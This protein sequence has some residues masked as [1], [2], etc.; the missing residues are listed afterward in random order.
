[1]SKKNSFFSVICLIFILGILNTNTV[2]ASST[3]GTINSTDKYAWGENIGWLNF[4]LADGN[5]HVTDSGLTGYA[6][7]ENYGWINLNANGTSGGRVTNNGEGVLGGN[8]WGEKLGWISFS[9]VTINS[10]GDF[11]GYA[12]I[13][14]DGSKISLNC[15][16]T[17]SCGLSNFKV[18]TDWR[19]ASTRPHGGGG[20]GGGG[21]VPSCTDKI[22]N[23]NETG[24][25][26]GGTCPNICQVIPPTSTEIPGCGN[27]TI[28]FSV[29]TGQS[30][31]GNTSTTPDIIPTAT[32][33]ILGSGPCSAELLITNNM[34]ID[35][36]NGKYSAYNKGIVTQVK[37][38]QTQIN[39][40]LAASYKQAAGPMDGFFGLLTK[41]GVERLQVALNNILKPT[42]L[43]V[44]DGIVGDFTKASINNSCGGMSSQTIPISSTISEIQKI[45]KDLQFGSN[46]NDVK[47]LQLFLIAQNKGPAALAL[48]NHVLTNYFGILTKAALI[49]WQKV[50]NIT[51]A[52]GY[53]GLK[54]REKIKLLNL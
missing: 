42:P 11:L 18:N 47:T 54:T 5:V 45:T 29:T 51:P 36:R 33:N 9:G 31:V 53:F 2:F 22:K 52:S 40:I 17:S 13:A 12:T 26:C 34:K 8:A 49:E 46:E 14:S 10:S 43:L 20:G 48:K 3:D 35:D 1:M 4:G 21:Y 37:I 32:E 24:I 27:R 39:R 41:Q 16:N 7:S 38:L 30:C 25:D 15:L 23:G 44:I 28:G 6:W 50:Y 19:P